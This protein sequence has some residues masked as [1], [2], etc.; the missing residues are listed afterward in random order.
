VRVPVWEE[1]GFRLGPEG[2]EKAITN[3]TRALMV[4]S[5][6]NPTGAV[7]TEPE[8][9]GI[10]ELAHRHNLAVISDEPYERLVYGGAEHIS[11]ASL[12]GMKERTVSIYS[13]SKTYA[14][15]GWRIGFAVADA[16]VIDHMHKMHQG[17]ASC[18]ASFVQKAA[19]TALDGP[20]DC[21]ERMVTDY[22]ARRRF[23]VNALNTMPGVVCPEP[24]GAFYLFPNVSGIGLPSYEVA[25]S[26]LHNEHVVCVPG[27]AFGP[28][29]EGHLRIS[30]AG[31]V[32]VLKIGVERIAAGLDRL[33]KL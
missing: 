3:R 12:P 24:R 10:A 16:P 27:T 18:V 4:N 8:L 17:V 1:D 9:Q 29:G 20:Q 19:V 22:D 2:V 11:I 7:L 31:S 15:T 6:A 30:F 5:P 13:L 23:M 21:V 33:R 14:M 26:L 28:R 32:E 25:T